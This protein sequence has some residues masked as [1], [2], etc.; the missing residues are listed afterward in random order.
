VN[1]TGNGRPEARATASTAAVVAT[2]VI[3]RAGFAW[4]RLRAGSV[5]APSFAHAAHNMAA[6]A[7]VRM[8]SGIDSARVP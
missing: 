1:L 6:F 7:G 8:T 2:T 5:L 3:A 4:L